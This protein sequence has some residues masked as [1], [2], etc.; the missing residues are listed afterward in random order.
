MEPI[1]QSLSKIRNNEEEKI[2]A[3]FHKLE[4]LEEIIGVFITKMEEKK[5]MIKND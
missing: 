1:M 4:K 5:N 3:L 2:Q